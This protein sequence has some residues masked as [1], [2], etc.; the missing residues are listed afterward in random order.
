LPNWENN[1][2]VCAKIIGLV[3]EVL[4]DPNWEEPRYNYPGGTNE[5]NCP[6]G[7]SAP[8]INAWES[9]GN[10]LA[11]SILSK[12]FGY[13]ILGGYNT[14]NT[15]RRYA[16]DPRAEKMM[17]PR[18]TGTAGSSAMRWLECNIGMETSMKVTYYPDLYAESGQNPYTSNTGYI[19]LITKEEL[20]FIKAEAQYWAGDKAAA[21]NTTKE[22]VINS[23]VRFGVTESVASDGSELV[24][25]ASTRYNRFLKCA[26]RG[27]ASL[28]L[29]T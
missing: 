10:R 26:C 1:P 11:S 13:A 22:A 15:N 8:I 19:A 21:F 18:E 16:L 9:R 25:T 6:W 23:M 20:L 3:D 4:N 14:Q 17:T 7:S 28:R 29:P 12:F 2:T 24:G 5:Q 27:K